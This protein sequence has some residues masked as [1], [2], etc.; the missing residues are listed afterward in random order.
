MP[1]PAYRLI[2]V[3]LIFTNT[4]PLWYQESGFLKKCFSKL[5]GLARLIVRFKATDRD[6][7]CFRGLSW[8][9]F[10]NHIVN[11]VGFPSFK[12]M[13]KGVEHAQL[14]VSITCSILVPVDSTYRKKNLTTYCFLI[15]NSILL[16]VCGHT[17]PFKIWLELKTFSTIS[18]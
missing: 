14:H 10:F 12:I 8:Q 3:N 2:P 7:L 4:R 17:L 15:D 16:T 13:S 1:T 18:I 11:C 6:Q 5:A 9:P